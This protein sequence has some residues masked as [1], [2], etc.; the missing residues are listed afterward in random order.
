A[1]GGS[2]GARPRIRAKL[3]SGKIPILPGIRRPLLTVVAETEVIHPGWVD[4]EAESAGIVGR[5]RP[6]VSPVPRSAGL[7]V[8]L[9]KLSVRHDQ[10]AR[11]VVHARVDLNVR[12]V[13]EVDEVF[14]AI[15]LTIRE[16]LGRGPM[17]DRIGIAASVEAHDGAETRRPAILSHEGQVRVL[18][19]IHGDDVIA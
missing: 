18:I 3:H 9:L 16:L 5:E 6:I 14:K 12:R 7:V 11:S 10:R 8:G 4:T 13:D 2:N 17:T 1:A 15:P 19:R